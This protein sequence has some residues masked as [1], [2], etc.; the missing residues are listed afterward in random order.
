[1]FNEFELIS[2]KY[3]DVPLGL[4]IVRGDNIVLFGDIN[5]TNESDNIPNLQKITPEQLSLL[6][7][8]IQV[9][10]DKIVFDFDS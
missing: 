1:M 9:E 7:E 8:T 3:C 4:Y 5:N 6:N 2:G 10:E